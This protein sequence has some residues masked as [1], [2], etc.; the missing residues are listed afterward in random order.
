MHSVGA[1][2]FITGESGS[3]VKFSGREPLL[4]GVKCTCQ[5][6]Q[7]QRDQ[8]VSYLLLSKRVSH[9]SVK[10]SAQE[11]ADYVLPLFV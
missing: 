5:L 11:L 2:A 10:D 8:G 3:E 7:R 9:R 1:M 6:W 4:G